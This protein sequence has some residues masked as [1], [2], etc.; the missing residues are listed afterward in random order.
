MEIISGNDGVENIR[1]THL[2]LISEGLLPGTQWAAVTTHSGVTRE[3]PQ[4]GKPVRVWTIACQG[5]LPFGA[6]APPTILVFG[7]RPQAP[8]E[9]TAS[10]CPL[11][12]K[13]F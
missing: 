7:P 2:I 10:G 4:N 1:V 12:G 3:P 11:E 6:S 13:Y 9:E 8:V 5:Q